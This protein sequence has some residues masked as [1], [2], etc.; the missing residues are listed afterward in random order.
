MADLLIKAVEHGADTKIITEHIRADIQKMHEGGVKVRHNKNI[1]T[2]LFVAF[3]R[4]NDKIEGIS[5]Q[6]SFDFDGRGLSGDR[7][8]TGIITM[9]PD[10]V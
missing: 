4:H 10:L 1:H 2:R 6:G 9:H 3:N 8:D 7:R 5:I